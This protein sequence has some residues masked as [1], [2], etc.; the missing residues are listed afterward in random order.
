MDD[1]FRQ[2]GAFSWNELITPDLEAAKQFYGTLFG[3]K[4]QDSP[5]EGLTYTMVE[6]GG[7]E[8]GGMM[9]TPPEAQGMPPMW[10]SYVTVDDVD[11]IA[12]R[13]AELGGSLLVEPRDI[14]GVGRFC[15]I[16]DPQGAMISAISYLAPD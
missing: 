12:E 9:S 15:V 4:T 16:R 11:Q 6:A 14:P 3:W 7:R 1:I 2:H 13:A 8:V 10:G 5:M